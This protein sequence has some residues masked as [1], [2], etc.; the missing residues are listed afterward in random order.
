MSVP[1][2]EP[3]AKR[4]KVR[5]GT[6]S[7]WECRQRKVKCT[8]SSLDD[9]ICITCHRRGAKCISQVILDGPETAKSDT[10]DA[11]QDA[12][13]NLR[14]VSESGVRSQPDA[15]VGCSSPTPFARHKTPA[16]SVHGKQKNVS[17]R[18]QTEESPSQL[19]TPQLPPTPVSSHASIS[20]ASAYPSIT[21]ALRSSLPPRKDIEILLANLSSMSIFC[22][23][24]SFKLCSSW[25]SE[26]AKEQMPVAN[27]LYSE[28]HPVLLARQMLLFA[29]GLQH[30]SPTKAIP[31][32]TKHHRAIM[33][34]LADS[35]IKLVNTND[36][37]LGTLE[38]LE[39]LILEGFYHIDGGNIRRSWITMRRAVMTAQLLGLHR[40]GHYRFKI[41][42]QQNDLD[43]AVMWACVVST[44]QFLCLLLGLPTSTSG[45][46]FTIPRAT[47]ACVESGN[48]PVLIPD[49]VRKIIE[50]NQIHAP[51]EAL[52]MT[53]EIDQELLRV[54]EQWPPT[55]WRPLQL[56]GLEVDS[57]DAFWETRRVWDHIFYYSLVNQLHLPYM[58]NPR[59]T[60]Q[61]V[62]S[63]IACASAS[64]E[65]LIRQIAIRTFNPVTA[66][67][68]MGDFVAL[69]AGMTLML[70]HILSHC[71]KGTGNLLIHQR[72]GDRATV[73]RALECMESMSELHEDVLTAK[74][75]A[76]LKNLLDIEA[77]P[78]ERHLDDGEG[79]VQNVLIVK[80]PYV[81]AIRIARDG[82][83]IAPFDTEQEQVPHEGV[84]IGG[85]G[86][87][88]VRTP[89]L[90]DHHADVATSDAAASRA[91]AEA[92]GPSSARQHGGR[93]AQ[94]T[95]GDVFSLPEDPFPDASA[96]ME[97][98]L[99]QGL[100]TAFFDVLMS[101][102]G[103]PPLNGTDTEGWNFTVSQ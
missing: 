53:Q 3:A 50:R 34:Q 31:G 21:Q 9:A 45:A 103:E 41:A 24:S 28:S 35:A 82:I 42:N 19:A 85:F 100:D 13:I 93:V 76:L 95:S 29:V 97:E 15:T 89:R 98:W 55:F 8:F 5:K 4:R 65:I 67:C 36:V 12:A 79:D 73:E 17:N 2:D 51:Q 72:V 11:E 61:R 47:S 91:T 102:A 7:C 80:V 49:V 94:A 90:S 43:P 70:A 18:L 69:I 22:Y 32:L 44:E 52:E 1:S 23:Q 33:E 81:G 75:A 60:S 48:L 96:G 59:H 20:E 84:T 16:S 56:A 99:F 27:L 66:G 87:I 77:G 46:N 78:A 10:G 86:S 58:L 25:P 39:N 64:R 26:L 38:G 14:L 57:A 88:H 92:L 54:T 71:N 83:S 68:R 62:Y 37:L 6:H 63:R 101:G 30:L 40:P 74:C